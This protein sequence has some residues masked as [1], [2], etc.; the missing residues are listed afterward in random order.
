VLHE[1]IG[2]KESERAQFE[3]GARSKAKMA[4]S[5]LAGFCFEEDDSEDEYDAVGSDLVN[6]GNK[7]SNVASSCLFTL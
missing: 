6:D 3:G 7:F 5:D 1:L 2:G 4:G